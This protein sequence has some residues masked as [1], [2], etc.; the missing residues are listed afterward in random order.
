[1]LAMRAFPGALLPWRSW[2][3]W[4]P[5]APPGAPYASI[6]RPLDGPSTWSRP[7]CAA[8][9]TGSPTGPGQ[10]RIV[11][12]WA[13]WCEP[14]QEQFPVLAAAGQGPSGR[15]AHR[16]RGGGGRGPGPG[17]GLPGDDPAPLHGALGQGRGAPRRAARHRAAPH[18]AA[19]GPGRAGPLRPPGLPVAG[20]RSRSTARSG[21]CSPNHGEVGVR[22]DA[23]HL[24][25]VRRGLAQPVDH[26]VRL[27]LVGLVAEAGP[28]RRRPAAWPGP[29]GRRPGRAPAPRSAPA[30]PGRRRRSPSAP[31]RRR[32]SSTGGR[33]RP[34]ARAGWPSAPAWCRPRAPAPARA[35]PARG[36]A[37]A[38]R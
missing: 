12:F 24:A 5:G 2:S 38:A 31:C 20:R 21:G 7:T 11:D 26:L 13:T 23:L 4:V 18:H 8:T 17:G 9:S 10:V 34:P 36:A 1:M 3:W 6:P 22:L 25:G 37:A 16:L 35:P 33:P 32:G 19:G 30:A 29:A 14:C 28:C 27:P 15:R